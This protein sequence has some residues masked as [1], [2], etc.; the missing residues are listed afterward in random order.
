[1]KNP[2]KIGQVIQYQS[3]LMIIVGEEQDFYYA[4]L[5]QRTRKTSLMSTQQ[6]DWLSALAYFTSIALENIRKLEDT[7]NELNN[8]RS[9]SKW[10]SKLLFNISEKEHRRIANDIH[11]S[12]LQDLISLNRRIHD[13]QTNTSNHE[14]QLQ[15]QEAEEEILD[16][17]YTIR[18][19]LHELYPTFLSEFGLGSAL[20]EL[21]SKF[22]LRC[23][24]ALDVNMGEDVF[25]DLDEDHVLAVYRI[26]QELLTNAKKHSQADHIELIIHREDRELLIFY[27]DDGIGI[28]EE[29]KN[30]YKQMGIRGIEE[31]VYSLDG[32]IQFKNNLGL[33]VHIRIPI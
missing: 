7:I 12:F 20:D 15:L 8:I 19:T 24:I 22:R 17:I 21:Y 9:K 3:S 1:M 16:I 30:D 4:I 5:G 27:K 31:R 13:I 25:K 32:N 23:N 29:N 28:Q 18:E 2:L 11:D 26:V 14:H 10:L 6:N 33:S